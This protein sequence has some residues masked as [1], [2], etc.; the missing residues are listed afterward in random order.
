MKC[1]NCGVEIIEV[2][3]WIERP[4]PG[5]RMI[6]HP[7]PPLYYKCKQCGTKIES[8]GYSSEGNQKGEKRFES[9][10]AVMSRLLVEAE[11]E[12]KKMNVILDTGA[13]RSYIRSELTKEFP[14][15]PVQTFEVK[16][17]GKTF[18]VK[19]VRLVSGTI[20]DTEG[21]AYQFGNVL[22]PLSD[23]G[24]ENGKR[25]DLLFGAVILEDWG[26]IINESTIP[27]QV[28]YYRLRKG[29]LTEL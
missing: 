20:K 25:I 6:G 3:G 28:D 8:K 12:G 15:I 5:G 2:F 24:R 14:V 4:G 23:L 27:P 18:R 21:R 9:R 11:A 19:E 29:E 10:V 1:P 17:G 7:G 16:L 22:Y 26:A 13:W